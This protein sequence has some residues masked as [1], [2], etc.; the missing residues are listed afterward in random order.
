MVLLDI[1][2]TLITSKRRVTKTTINMVRKIIDHD[3]KV[4][5]CTGRNER[6]TKPVLKKLGVKL[7]YCCVGGTEIYDENH[8]QIFSGNLESNDI[9]K[10]LNLIKEEDCFVQLTRREGYYHYVSSPEAKKYLMFGSPSVKDFVAR[11]YIGMKRVKTIETLMLDQFNDTNEII[12]GG[13]DETLARVKNMIEENYKELRVKDD[14]WE[15]YLFVGKPQISKSYAMERLCEYYNIGA[16][17]VIAIGDDVNDC[18]MLEK[19][20][21]GIAMGNAVDRVKDCSDDITLTNDLDGVAYALEH[22]IINKQHNKIC[23]SV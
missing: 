12:I 1:D 16:E 14:L 4:V 20:G 17:A 6:L 23:Y 8:K 22:Y 11:K 13:D 15:H 21:L 3:I 5:I 19:A 10:V 7:P 9:S 18:D 2:G